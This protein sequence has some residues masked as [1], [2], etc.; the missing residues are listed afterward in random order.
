MDFRNQGKE[1]QEEMDNFVVGVF[2]RNS[3]ILTANYDSIN[4]QF[5]CTVGVRA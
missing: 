1:Y 3:C 2:N 4:L 5:G